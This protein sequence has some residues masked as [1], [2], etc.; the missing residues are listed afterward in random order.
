[1]PTTIDES[2]QWKIISCSERG[3]SHIRHELPNQDAFFSS[4]MLLGHDYPF[5]VLAVADGHGSLKSFRSQT[6]SK[7]AV[8]EAVR[9]CAEFLSKMKDA[10][11]STVKNSAE[12]S[13]TRYIIE[14][15]KK[16]VNE[17]MVEHPFSQ[18]ELGVLPKEKRVIAYGSTLLMAAVTD[19]FLMYF[20]IG[21]GEIIEVSGKDGQ[22]VRPIPK[23]ESLIANETTSLCMENPLPEFRFRFQNIAELPPRI[24][25]LSTDGYPN[26]FKSQEGFFKVGTDLLEKLQKE[27]CE[28]VAQQLPEWLQ[29]A[30][31]LGSG[32]D[33]T[34][35]IL[36]R[37]GP[38]N[39][40][41]GLNTFPY[42]T[43]IKPINKR[44]WYWFLSFPFYFLRRKS[45]L[46]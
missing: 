29:E 7:F 10:D 4:K 25:L 3:A 34:L 43:P 42:E 14:A 13:L 39:N 1:M 41:T 5:E 26:S 2:F 15:W 36:Y 9:L 30:S 19:R 37:Q 21:D 24:I 6:G 28:A 32:D 27:G 12:Q 11:L 40:Q 38:E 46:N 22:V 44:K 23:D 18:P 16:R 31:N 35:G 20:Q 33:V 17:D 45:S 8:E